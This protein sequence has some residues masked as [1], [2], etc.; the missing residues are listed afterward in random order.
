MMKKFSASIVVA[1]VIFGSGVAQGYGG[2]SSG[3][4]GS[5]SRR[6]TSPGIITDGLCSDFLNIVP[7]KNATVTSL[8]ELTFTAPRG[9]VASSVIVVLNGEE[10]KTSVKEKANEDLAVKATLPSSLSQKSTV[11]VS[12]SARD[13]NGCEKNSVYFIEIDPNSSGGKGDEEKEDTGTPGNNEE[14]DFSDTN[15]H[16]AKSYIESM[17]NRGIASG[18]GDGNFR[19]DNIINRSEMTKIVLNALKKGA[20]K[21]GVAPFEDVPASNWAA[22]YVLKAKELGIVS[23]YWNNRFFEPYSGGTRAVV[24]KMLVEAAG[25][26]VAKYRGTSPFP[27]V[28]ASE[29]Y[30]PYVTWAKENGIVGGYAGGNFG[31]NNTVTR[32]EMAKIT[33]NFLSFIG[34]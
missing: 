6:G 3:G 11:K 12:L 24:I 34:G 4:G 18:Y 22:P 9:Y 2:S 8:S 20:G 29:W 15:S 26:D 5:S 17:V 33:M 32:G 28:P 21:E 31:P 10:L 27:D 1:L 7:G 13:Q 30:A 19:P 25:I 16:W 14:K 23:G